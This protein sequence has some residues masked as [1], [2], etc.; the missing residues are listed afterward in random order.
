MIAFSFRSQYHQ[1]I[2][3]GKG[4]GCVYK[5]SQSNWP[6]PC[7]NTTFVVPPISMSSPQNDFSSG[8]GDSM[9][10][11]ICPSPISNPTTTNKVDND[12]NIN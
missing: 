10:D 2:N 8:Y 7:P 12:V 1:A 9:I 11:L 4:A 3:M 6:Y 5:N